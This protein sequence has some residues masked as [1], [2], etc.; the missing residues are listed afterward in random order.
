MFPGG[1]FAKG[2]GKFAYKCLV[3]WHK[4]GKEVFNEQQKGE[5]L[6]PAARTFKDMQ[7]VW[8]EAPEDWPVVGCGLGFR[9]FCEGPSMT[10]SVMTKKDDG[11]T[12]WEAM[13]AE[14]LPTVLD[15]A[16][17]KARHI[18]LDRLCNS[19]D[20]NKVYQMLPMSFPVSPEGQVYVSDEVGW[21][22]APIHKRVFGVMQY[23]VDKWK[24]IGAPFISATS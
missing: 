3:E 13:M 24:Q 22:E 2:A 6:G 21:G 1:A 23:P 19:M 5:E 17:K 10:L 11:E 14:R 8:S 15:D 18:S 7:K 4:L 20:P 9:P 16:I 12:K